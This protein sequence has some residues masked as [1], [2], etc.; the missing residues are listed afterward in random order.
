MTDQY[1]QAT[2][3]TRFEYTATTAVIG[4]MF[5]VL[6]H[7]AA[8]GGQS[9]LAR[10]AAATGLPKPT[11]HRLVKDLKSWGALEAG[12]D[13]LRLGPRLFELGQLV[14][15]TR[16]LR[17]AALPFM[18]DLYEA[19]HETIHLGVLTGGHVV[20]IEKITGH[21]SGATP[22]RV[23]G[24]MPAPYT[25]IGKVLLAYL[26]GDAVDV[27]VR[28][29]GP[30]RTPTSISSRDVLSQALA[31]VRE[32][33]VAFDQEESQP[34]LVC[35]AAPVFDRAGAVVAGLSVAGPAGR[36]T[37][38]RFEAAVLTAAHGVRRTLRAAPA[39]G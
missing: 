26:P 5:A 11:V 30:P 31:T 1:P 13:W 38:A 35:V 24:R 27:A 21:H 39:G 16:N 17:S 25:G 32:R 7:V 18:Q 14:P 37:P 3:Q 23:G 22:T 28:A 4:K 8:A 29:A 6:D 20:Y 36:F 34:G 19:T 12:G 9:T 2:G 10:I 33:G 15:H